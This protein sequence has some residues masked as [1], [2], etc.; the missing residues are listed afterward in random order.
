MFIFEPVSRS[1]RISRAFSICANV[2]RRLSR[3]TCWLLPVSI[4]RPGRQSAVRNL[5]A[6]RHIC[7]PLPEYLD[8]QTFVVGLPAV[9]V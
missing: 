4:A 7:P 3:T 2:S 6:A 9:F 1:T 8:L 5:R